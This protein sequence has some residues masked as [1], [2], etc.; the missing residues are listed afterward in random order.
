MS[1]TT[2]TGRVPITL[3][4]DDVLPG[5]GAELH[6][7]TALVRSLSPVDMDTTTRC[8]GWTVADVVGH[9]VGTTTDIINGRFD[10]MGSPAGTQRQAD[11][12]RGRS[13]DELASELEGGAATLADLLRS[14]PDEVWATPWQNDERYTM[15]FAIEAIWYDAYMHGDDI[16]AALGREADRSDGLRCAVHH[17]A[18]YLS[19]LRP[20]PATLALD[21]MESID[22]HGGG[23]TITGDPHSFVLAATGRLDPAEL[24]LDPSINVYAPDL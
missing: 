17:V 10:D 23:P 24:G 20:S 6:R 15:G 12:R 9:V 11:E 1:A 14:L 18:G 19:V 7:F 4:R 13:P 5:I 3:G 22:L 16:R 21:G 2:G 8:D